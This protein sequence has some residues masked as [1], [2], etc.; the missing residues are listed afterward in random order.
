VSDSCSSSSRFRV[1]S[2][3]GVKAMLVQANFA[4]LEAEVEAEAA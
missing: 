1:R 3:A 4:A 2:S